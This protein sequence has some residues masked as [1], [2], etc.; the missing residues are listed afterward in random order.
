MLYNVLFLLLGQTR[1][2]KLKRRYEKPTTKR[3]RLQYERAQR[4]YNENIKA[5]VA[6]LLRGQRDEYPWS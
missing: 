4:I 3:H 6:L 1:E 5:K 2:V